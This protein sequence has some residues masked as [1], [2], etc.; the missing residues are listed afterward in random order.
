MMSKIV[1]LI[2]ARGGSKGIPQKNIKP[3]AGKPLIAWTIEAA[4]KSRYIDQ[5]LVSTDDPQIAQVA[6]DCGAEV[7]FLRPS[8]LAQDTSS[9]IS[10][11]LHAIAW[12]E[13][14]EQTFPDYLLL[15]QPTSPLRTSDDIDRA[16]ELALSRDARAVVSVTEMSPHPYLSKPLQ[17]D[18]TLGEFFS[19]QMDYLRRQDLPPAYALNGAVYLNKII[20]LK[21][22]RTFLPA[23]TLAYVMP[24]ERSMD[25][26]TTWDFYLA[27]LILGEKLGDDTG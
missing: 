7:P 9:H 15:L 24:A 6:V 25:I 21:E 4:L 11:V 13:E 8:E 14:N 12:L 2:T 3:L 19:V 10:V 5:V 16:V 1:A 26:D 18:G 27:N 20:S 17:A 22:D 23:G